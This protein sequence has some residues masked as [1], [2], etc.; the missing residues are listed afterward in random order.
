VNQEFPQ[1]TNPE[2]AARLVIELD[3]GRTSR[4]GRWRDGKRRT[5]EDL[6]GVM[7][8]EIEARTPTEVLGHRGWRL[9]C[10]LLVECRRAGSQSCGVGPSGSV[11]WVCQ[12]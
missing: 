10:H 12:V 5:L 2:R 6:L 1:S 11:R 9:D 3:H 4:Q 8:G 7:L